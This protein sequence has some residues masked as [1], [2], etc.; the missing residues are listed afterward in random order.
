MRDKARM[1]RAYGLAGVFVWEAGQDLPPS[2]K[3]SLL[4]TL[5]KERR[6]IISGKAKG[7]DAGRTALHR[8]ADKSRTAG[9]GHKQRASAG[10]GNKER[11]T[12]RAS[13]L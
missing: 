5:A 4:S 6:R 1:A 3:A 8:A 2:S 12:A 9:H 11:K 7:S 10:V 13:E